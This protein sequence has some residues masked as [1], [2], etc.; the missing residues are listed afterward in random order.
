MNPYPDQRDYYLY[1]ARNVIT[2]IRLRE[3][4]IIMADRIGNE[5]PILM[6]D[7]ARR[8][9]GDKRYE[10]QS[11]DDLLILRDEYH[12]PIGSNSGQ[13]GRWIIVDSDDLHHTANE[14]ESRGYK[15]IN[16]ARKMRT[17]NLRPKLTPEAQV[18]L[19]TNQGRLWEG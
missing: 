15:L 10:R 9:Y 19:E 5:H 13:A 18:E 1:I 2:D 3:T 17:M 14:I 16:L 8:V 12:I 11:R 6:K 4:L 7:L